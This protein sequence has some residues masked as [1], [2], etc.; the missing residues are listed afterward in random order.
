[1]GFEPTIFCESNRCVNRFTT[2]A[3]IQFKLFPTSL[4]EE[5]NIVTKKNSKFFKELNLFA[6]TSIVPEDLI[7]NNLLYYHK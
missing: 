2:L 7:K 3:E 6:G 5:W 1:M 4:L